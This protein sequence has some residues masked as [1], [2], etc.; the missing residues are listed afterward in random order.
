MIDKTKSGNI[1]KKY[2]RLKKCKVEIMRTL[3][4]VY[5]CLKLSL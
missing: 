1:S 3:V 5:K 2:Y 4:N